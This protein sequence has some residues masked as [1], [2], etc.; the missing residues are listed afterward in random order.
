MSTSRIQGIVGGILLCVAAV[1]PLRTTWNM[2]NYFM[3]VNDFLIVDQGGWMLVAAGVLAIAAALIGRP[4]GIFLSSLFS[5]AV[6]AFI[7]GAVRASYIQLTTFGNEATKTT[8]KL[9]TASWGWL[10]VI[11]GV[12]LVTAAAILTNV[13]QNRA[14]TLQTAQQPGD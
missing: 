7:A 8:G 5:T 10:F 1:T 13:R 11:G 4:T 3:A 9:M 2:S 14:L 12:A 6:A